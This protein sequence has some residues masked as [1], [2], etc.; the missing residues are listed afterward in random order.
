MVNTQAEEQYLQ[1]V[2]HALKKA[3]GQ[4]S[5]TLAK[6]QSSGILALQEMAGDVRLNFDNFADNLDTFAQLE[7]KNR[8]IDQLNLK[9]KTAAS[10]LAQVRRL[11]PQAYFGKVVVDYFDEE[12]KQS[13]YIGVN[14][15]N[16][17]NENLVYDW[18]SP[19]AELFYNNVLGPSAYWANGKKIPVAIDLRRQFVISYDRLKHYFDTHIAIEDDVLLAALGNSASQQMQAITATIQK[20]QN[21]IIRDLDHEIIL[22]NGV[23][24]SGKTSTIMQR[25]AYLLYSLRQEISVDDVLILAPNDKFIQYLAHVL[26]SLGEKNPRNLTWRKLLAWQLDQPLESEIDYFT[27]ITKSEVDKQTTV[28]RSQ[29]FAEFVDNASDILQN[30]NY[31]QKITVKQKVIIKAETIAEMFATTPKDATFGQRIQSV[32]VKLRSYWQRRLLKQAQGKAWQ[33]RVLAL[34]ENQQQKYFGHLL[35]DESPKALKKYALRLLQQKYH[36]IEVAITNFS[37]L[38]PAQMLADLYLAYTGERYQAAEVLTV[39]EAT[40]ALLIQHRFI[41]TSPLATMKYILVDEVQDYTPAQIFLL[42]QLFTNARFTLV[43]DYN[44][45]IFNSQTDFTTIGAIFKATKREVIVYD[46][47]NSYRSSG[48]ITATFQQL[49]AQVDFTIV[50]V[51]PKGK[52]VAVNKLVKL[53]DLARLLA[54]EKSVTVITKTQAEADYLTQWWHDQ[55]IMFANENTTK[56]NVTILP[57]SLAKGLEFDHVLLY[58]ASTENYTT[59]QDRK[60]LYTATSRGMQELTITYFEELTSLLQ[61]LA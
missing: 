40:I 21:V 58:N 29:K 9:Q 59:E 1:K 23:A 24:G 38:Q 57:I 7:M 39:D 19:V 56:E 20:E 48:A 44:Q 16:D 5:E 33:D 27:R 12:E 18:R 54:I 8:E 60:M 17:E 46:L 43:G 61:F 13:F 15:F 45:A 2:Y 26:P 31:F 25:I 10:K 50:P 32:A 28:L 51:R 14:S 4:L 22:V 35:Q 42:N 6:G 37:W 36:E 11:L 30:K 41:K 34:S 3:E 47:L 49:T 52:K 53:T 55:P